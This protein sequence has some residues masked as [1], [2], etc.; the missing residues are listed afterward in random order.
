MLLPSSSSYTDYNM[1]QI[2]DGSPYNGYKLHG[3]GAS[4]QMGQP[5]PTYGSRLPMIQAPSMEYMTSPQQVTGYALPPTKVLATAKPKDCQGECVDESCLDEGKFGAEN[6]APSEEYTFLGFDLKPLLPAALASSTVIGAICMLLVQIPI[7]SRFAYVW[8]VC[9]F[10]VFGA[11]YGLTLGCMAYCSFSDPGQMR[12][13]KS[14]AR[15]AEDEPWQGIMPKRAHQS[16]QYP[17]PVRRYDHY[18]KWLQNVIGLLNHREFVMMLSGLTMI[19]ALGMIVDVL[20]AILTARDGFMGAMIIV[21]LHLAY[22]IVLLGVVGPMFN[23][24]IGLVSRNELAQEWKNNK[25]YI[26]TNS[27]KGENVPVHDL[28]DDEYN[29]LFDA[30]AFVYARSSNEWDKGCPDNCLSFWCNARWP[31]DEKG[32]W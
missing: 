6:N 27:S 16:W 5:V 25:H 7:L 4:F 32:E 15:G 20:V 18:C 30:D 22:S 29:E 8:Q 24:H 2:V 17:R 19:S 28:D 12:K 9:L 23:I 31:K 10:A 1:K 11:L 3:G 14:A 21:L 13:P 26:V